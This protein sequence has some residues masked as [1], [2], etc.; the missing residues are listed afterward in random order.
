MRYYLVIILIAAFNL[1]AFAQ[2][3]SYYPVGSVN[4]KEN[5]KAQQNKKN[6]LFE[7]YFFKALKGKSI[8]DYEN[9]VLDFEK[10]TEI[11]PKSPQPFYELAMIYAGKGRYEIATERIKEAVKIEPNNKWYELLYAEILFA[12]QDFSNATKQ[13]KKLIKL[14]PL[15][16]DL[17]FKLSEAYL[18]TGQFKKAIRVYDEL[19]KKKGF[20][21]MLCIQK[22]KL[23]R[24]LND[25]DGA[26]NELLSILAVLTEDIQVMEM[27]SE[28]YILNDDQEMAFKIF[29]SI[30]DIDPKNGRIHLTLADYYRSKGEKEK[31]YEELKLAFMS[32][33]LNVDIK[34]RILVSY[35]QLISLSEEMQSQA[36]ELVDILIEKHPENP[37]VRVVYADI[38]YSDNKHQKAKKQ[39]L[40]ALEKEKNKRDLWTQVLFI[41]AEENDFEGVLRTSEEALEY[42]P[43]EPLFYYFNGVSKKWNENYDGAIKSLLTGIE[44][45]F[46]NENLILEFY[47]SLAESY[48][49]KKSHKL[50]DQYY[51]KA[52]EIDSNNVLVLNNYSYF[53]SVRKT[54]LEKALKMS[55][56]CNEIVKDN[57]TYQDTY[58]WVLYQLGEYKKSKE[59]LSKALLNG[60]DKSGVIVEHY[61]DVLYKLGDFKEAILQW[62]KAKKIGGA[63]KF[64]DRKISEGR[65]YE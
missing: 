2:W 18:Y 64:I 54:N 43:L 27:L 40:F 26:I 7:Q 29:K 62:Q 39:Y 1:C 24:E 57:G 44:F 41:Q 58:A 21:K 10:C 52:L 56:K 42:F 51:E 13:Y 22:H 14:E 47:I 23:Y 11:N 30:S 60:G 65:L 19:Q 35:Y 59:W 38:L 37:K 31:S 33:K 61:G 34:L 5:K 55:F 25:I 28:L 20:D 46:D 50:S 49:A 3:K 36:Y 6:K 4:I 17:Y 8:E 45:V 53:L 32:T 12:K 16:E 63:G 15:N 48:N 9:A